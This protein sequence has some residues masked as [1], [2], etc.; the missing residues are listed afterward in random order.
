MF[1]R[2]PRMF[3][4]YPFWPFFKMWDGLVAV[5]RGIT[6]MLDRM[7]TSLVSQY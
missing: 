6:V 1:I 2:M 7:N 5:I 4:T 3:V